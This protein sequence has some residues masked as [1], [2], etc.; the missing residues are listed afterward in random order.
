VIVDGSAVECVQVRPYDFAAG[1][2]GPEPSD[3]EIRAT[4]ADLIEESGGI[5]LYVENS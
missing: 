5:A 2:F 3:D 4:V 1:T